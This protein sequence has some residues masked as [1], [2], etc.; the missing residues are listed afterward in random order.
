MA[1]RIRGSRSA[2]RPGGQALARARRSSEAA[3]SGS[4]TLTPTTWEAG[5]DEAI[6]VVL[7]EETA[8][9]VAD[10]PAPGT[11]VRAPKRVKVR[12]D[13]LEARVAAEDVYVRE[14]L[15]RI[16]VVSA[17]LVASLLVAWVVFVLLDAFGLYGS[18]PSGVPSAASP[19]R[20]ARRWPRWSSR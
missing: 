13:S 11:Q 1:K 19:R 10:R 9:T 3:P 16:A 14:D 15:R 8:I 2:H 12:A 6:D 5:I 20:P 18:G 7:L 17:I 4:G